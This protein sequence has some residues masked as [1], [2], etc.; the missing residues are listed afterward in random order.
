MTTKVS[1]VGYWVQQGEDDRVG[2]LILI[3]FLLE[4]IITHMHQYPTKPPNL[5]NQLSCIIQRE[6]K[7]LGNA[8]VTA[9]DRGKK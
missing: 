4:F 9:V 8:L 6:S 2:I 3:S 1:K 7:D 5:N